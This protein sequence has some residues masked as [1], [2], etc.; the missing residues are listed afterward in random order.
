MRKERYESPKLKYAPQALLF[1]VCIIICI[2]LFH[3]LMPVS[4]VLWTL[5]TTMIS[6]GVLI[7][8]YRIRR[9]IRKVIEKKQGSEQGET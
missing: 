5:L 3:D 1:V 7:L 9:P 4:P 6:C 8:V 2:V